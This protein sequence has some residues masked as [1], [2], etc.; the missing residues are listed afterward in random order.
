VD[1]PDLGARVKGF[2]LRLRFGRWEAQRGGTGYRMARIKGSMFCPFLI[3]YLV[4]ACL[5]LP[6]V[7]PTLDGII[8][9][10][11]ITWQCFSPDRGS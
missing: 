3:P 9:C 4:S 5:G 7:F 10:E 8:L 6:K 1:S 2:F 11:L